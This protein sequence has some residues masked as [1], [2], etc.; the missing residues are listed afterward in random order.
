MGRE[1]GVTALARR[2]K[3]KIDATYK[4]PMRLYEVARDLRARPSVIHRQFTYG[5]GMSPVDYRNRL[6]VVDSLKLLLMKGYRVGEAGHEV[7]FSHISRFTRNFHRWF[8]VPP[9]QFK[10]KPSGSA[11]IQSLPSEFH[12]ESVV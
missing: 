2:T 4:T 3:E 10:T 6:R 12:P 11:L 1:V 7:G 9:S 5:F 8:Q